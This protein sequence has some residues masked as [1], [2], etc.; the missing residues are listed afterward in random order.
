MSRSVRRPTEVGRKLSA[1]IRDAT[2]QYASECN[3]DDNDLA[4]HL[5]ITTAG[6]SVLKR[7]ESWTLDR[8]MAVAEALGL[9]V[10]IEVTPREG[11]SEPV[12]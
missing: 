6:V 11:L 10:A 4:R 2:L 12:P 5:R 7:R 8:S 3:L 9:D 1:A